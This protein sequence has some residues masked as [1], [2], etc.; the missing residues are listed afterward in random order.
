MPADRALA[1]TLSAVTV[2]FRL[3]DHGEYGMLSLALVLLCGA[4]SLAYALSEF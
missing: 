3:M 4:S 1:A 2:R